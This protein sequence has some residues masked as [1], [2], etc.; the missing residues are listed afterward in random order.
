MT[1]TIDHVPCKGTGIQGNQKVPEILATIKTGDED[2]APFLASQHDP[3]VVIVK[4]QR[5]SFEQRMLPRD[6]DLVRIKKK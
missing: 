4:E 3:A 6:G 2:L 5:E 1:V